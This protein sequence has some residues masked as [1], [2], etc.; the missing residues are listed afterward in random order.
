[1][2][3]V[4]LLPKEFRSVETNGLSLHSFTTRRNLVY[5]VALLIVLEIG[6]F[7]ESTFSAGPRIRSLEVEME[8]LEPQMKVVRLMEGKLQNI[9]VINSQLKFYMDR[10]F[11]WTE[12]LNEL[13][14]SMIPGLWLTHVE[15]KRQE[16]HAGELQDRQ[17]SQQQTG[18]AGVNAARREKRVVLV[19]RGRAAVYGDETA[20]LGKFIQRLK[21]QEAFSHLTEDIY[22]E[23]INRV[24]LSEK[25]LFEFSIFCVLKKEAES[26][27]YD[28]S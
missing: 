22:L 19:L 8:S 28:I 3:R 17:G 21:D 20:A 23:S 13:S 24:H 1:M 10:P 9:Q 25:Q 11:Y 14:E 18:K 6:F 26:E 2:I 4:N 5:F 15:A 7:M 12:I 16:F 27:F